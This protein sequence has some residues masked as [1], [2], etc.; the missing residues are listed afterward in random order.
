MTAVL[1]A[2]ESKLLERSLAEDELTEIC[3]EKK[4]HSE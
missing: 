1:L 2:M 3:H 4:P